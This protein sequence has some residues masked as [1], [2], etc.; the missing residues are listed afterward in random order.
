MSIYQ[1]SKIRSTITD[2]R[3]DSRKCPIERLL[4]LVALRK[5]VH[6]D[7]CTRLSTERNQAELAAM[8]CHDKIQ[9]W[10]EGSGRKR[11]GNELHGTAIGSGIIAR[12][13]STWSNDRQYNFLAETRCSKCP[14]VD[15]ASYL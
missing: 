5:C 15:F 13:T 8:K 10:A 9:L 11:P 6:H 2:C 1:Q 7:R 12:L 3:K 14:E 4:T